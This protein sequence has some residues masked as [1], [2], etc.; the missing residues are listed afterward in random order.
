MLENQRLYVTRKDFFDKYVFTIVNS[1][2]TFWEVTAKRF[3]CA[4]IEE[5]FAS[6]TIEEILQAFSTNSTNTLE[7]FKKFEEF[8]SENSDINIVLDFPSATKL[9]IFQ[10]MAEKVKEY[11]E[12]FRFLELENCYDFC[13]DNKVEDANLNLFFKELYDLKKSHA[14]ETMLTGEVCETPSYDD[15]IYMFNSLDDTLS[16]DEK[17][18]TLRHQITNQTRHIKRE[19]DITLKNSFEFRKVPYEFSLV[20]GPT[21]R[22]KVCHYKISKESFALL[23][24]ADR[25][26]IIINDKETCLQLY[27]DFKEFVKKAPKYNSKDY[28]GVHGIICEMHYKGFSIFKKRPDPSKTSQFFK[29]RLTVLGYDLLDEY[30]KTEKLIKLVNEKSSLDYE[31]GC[32]LTEQVEKDLTEKK[33]EFVRNYMSYDFYSSKDKDLFLSFAGYP[34]DESYFRLTKYSFKSQNNN[35]FDISVGDSLEKAEK[36]LYDL[37][38][39]KFKNGYVNAKL[40]IN[41][42][43]QNESIARITL[44]L[45]SKYLGNR[46]Y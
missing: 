1:K 43:M 7:D 20:Y 36:I 46:L 34:T 32:E 26:L 44:N 45:E 30:S 25:K 13:A 41:F 35:V 37:G 16:I 40:L 11:A 29:E 31:L 15:L 19:C 8:K 12:G 39:K 14:G 6:N 23:T 33:F 24:D 18:R 10:T 28:V 17:N 27:L 3:A 2:D 38:F 4:I 5:F 22:D 21:R 9:C 42:E